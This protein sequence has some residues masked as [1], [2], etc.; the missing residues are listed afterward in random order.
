MLR[1]IILLAIVVLAILSLAHFTGIQ[2]GSVIIFTPHTK[3]TIHLMMA[4]LLLLVSFVLCHYLLRL[5][6][7]LK[8]S[9][10]AWRQYQKQKTLAKHEQKQQLALLHLLAD[11]PNQAEYHFKQ[12]YLTAPKHYPIDLLLAIQAELETNQVLKAQ[13]DLSELQSRDPLIRQAMHILQTKIYDMKNQ[14]KAVIANIKQI[15]NY[16]NDHAR[17]SQ[18]CRNLL[19]SHQYSELLDEISHRSA[20]TADEKKY[21]GTQA[22]AQTL[23]D[24]LHKNQVVEA[25]RYA[26]NIPIY[27]SRTSDVMRYHL[28]TLLLCSDQ[29]QLGKML[30]KHLDTLISTIPTDELANVLNTLD[31]K[32]QEQILKLLNLIIDSAQ[33]NKSHALAL[34]AHLFQTLSLYEKA[35][36]DYQS[37]ISLHMHTPAAI[38]ARLSIHLLEKKKNNEAK[39]T[40]HLAEKAK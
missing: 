14:P 2:Q 39:M 12:A 21:W 8:S 25:K 32:N 7:F 1:K 24:M 28:Y 11:Q 19:A 38:N 26:E 20:L 36:A 15:K 23:A 16:R 34:R 9:P 35:I 29:H 10:K 17:V 3:I 33:D 30:N 13:N 37:L 18:L 4:C 27:Y 22:H 40:A 31:T 6:T 5:L